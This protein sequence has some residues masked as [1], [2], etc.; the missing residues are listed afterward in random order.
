MGYV[1]DQTG[2]TAD[3][4]QLDYDAVDYVVHAF[5][6]ANATTGLIVPVGQFDAYR[7]AGIVG[8]VHAAGK[9]IVFSAG[10]AADSYP[11]KLI[12]KDATLTAAF[13]D[14]VVAKI[15][16]WGYDGIDLDIEFPFGGD[17]P[18][19]HLNLVTAV[20]N[21]VKANNPAHVVLFGISPGYLL[22]E[23]KWPQLNA[24]SDFGFY[25]CYDWSNP[26]NGP[27]K[28]PGVTLT[29]FGGDTIEA[30]CRG[31][32]NYI[33]AAGYPAHKLIAGL[34]FYANGGAPWHSAPVGIDA[35][36]P[37]PDYMEVNS[38]G[39]WTTPTAMGMKID[40]VLDP[41][42]SVLTGSAVLAGV[43]WWQWG[44]EAVSDPALSQAIKLKLGK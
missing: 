8:K 3:L 42:S 38:D 1:F 41:A 15:N 35:I 5:I 26:A 22:A 12:A 24:V 6:T 31:A 40:A 37:H 13:A 20:Y 30:S 25:F 16:G 4:D 29:M 44:H 14:D 19:E 34:P 28:N 33:L 43:G 39:Y 36:T 23:Y 32:L 21:K 18:Q 2:G 27:I 10:G 11:L 7:Q 17:E 9:K